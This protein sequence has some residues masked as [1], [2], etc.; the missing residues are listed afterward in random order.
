MSE[1][2]YQQISNSEVKK[3]QIY[4]LSS[5]LDFLDEHNIEYFFIAGSLLGAVRHKGFIP[6]DDDVDIAIKRS[7]YN[8]FIDLSE[9]LNSQN[10]FLQNWHTDKEYALPFSKL[11]LNDSV[12]KESFTQEL[13]MHHGIYID[14][15]PFDS[16]CDNKILLILQKMSSMVLKKIISIQSGYKNVN[17]S[18]LYNLITKVIF[19]TFKYVPKTKLIH[20][21]ETINSLQSN[22]YSDNPNGYYVCTGGSYGFSKEMV[23]KSWFKNSVV[24]E[25][26]GLKVNAPNEHHNYLT[27]LYG[28]YL[29]LPSVEARIG[30]HNITD[31]KID[32]DLFKF[33]IEKNKIIHK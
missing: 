20:L 24:M 30:R 1:L 14:I 32:K 6:W 31:K 2:N 28:D 23:K 21:F 19:V 26:E 8:R 13:N 18:F 7:D 15:F 29:K 25:F 4:M 10:F 22:C 9:K 5:L 3:I 12:Y 11:R 27:N 16:V 33:I 17:T